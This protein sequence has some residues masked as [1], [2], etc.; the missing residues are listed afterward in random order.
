MPMKIKMQVKIETLTT[1][2]NTGHKFPN[3]V[4]PSTK[5]LKKKIIVILKYPSFRASGAKNKLTKSEI[6]HEQYGPIVF[7]WEGKKIFSH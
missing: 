6:N 5:D 7:W 4:Q 2:E 1:H 3:I